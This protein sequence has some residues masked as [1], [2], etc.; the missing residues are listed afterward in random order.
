MRAKLIL[1][2][3]VMLAVAGWWALYQLTGSIVPDRP[4]AQ[5]LFLGLLFLTLAATLTPVTAYLNR[6]LAPRASTQAPLRFIRHATWGGLCLTSWA[7]LQMHRIFNLGFAFI[8]VLIVVAIEL[9]IMRI[10][11]EL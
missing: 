6:R 5:V 1:I 3:A 9:F 10:R 7:W 2:L 8:T 11:N 4:G